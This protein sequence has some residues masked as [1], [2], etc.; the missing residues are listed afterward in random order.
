MKGEYPRFR[1]S[2]PRDEVV[3]QFVL[4]PQDHDL[5]AHCR[6]DVNCYGVAVLLKSLKLIS[7]PPFWFPDYEAY[8]SRRE[9][10]SQLF[11]ALPSFLLRI[12]GSETSC[13][14]ALASCSS[15]A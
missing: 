14:T 8:V 12:A 11:A 3:V 7:R 6:E 9:G 2:Y 13:S 5:I 10:S 15:V 1:A 4:T